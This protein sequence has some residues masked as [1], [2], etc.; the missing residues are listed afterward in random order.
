MP[1]P[2]F[3]PQK[4]LPW[5]RTPTA[6]LKW[7]PYSQTARHQTS[8]KLYVHLHPVPDCLSRR[9]RMQ[10]PSQPLSPYPCRWSLPGVV[11][12][13]PAPAGSSPA[14]SARVHLTFSPW[15][16]SGQAEKWSESWTGWSTRQLSRLWYVSFLQSA[17]SA[18][19][20]C[21]VPQNPY[22]ACRTPKLIIILYLLYH[23]FVFFKEKS[24]KKSYDFSTL[25]HV[26]SEF[27]CFSR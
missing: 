20:D 13:Y 25:F 27:L 17:F 26:F 10:V 4:R 16:S 23:I 9:S 8:D 22:P 2:L 5:H 7:R 3:R 14:A 12:P 21:G 6:H 18:C 24:A 19:V 1:H 15:I 11:P